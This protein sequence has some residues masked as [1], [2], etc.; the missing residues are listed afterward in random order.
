MNINEIRQKIEDLNRQY[1]DINSQLYEGAVIKSI[2]ELDGQTEVLSSAIPNFEGL[3]NDL[4][5]ISSD[6]V[7]YKTLLLQANNKVM[8]NET[9]TIQ[10]GIVKIQQLR[11]L[12]SQLSSI[13][14]FKPTK[15][16]RSDNSNNS[17][18]Y[19]I[20][21]LNFSKIN[22]STKCEEILKKVNLLE[23]Q[24]SK[25]NELDYII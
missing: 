10:A 23:L 1:S 15:L 5:S 3:L 22:L 24:I 20:S 14:N 9:D 25:A 12:H 17:A 21:E 7:K 16:R 11:K 4:E 18:Y 2:K 8:I 13:L 19:Q 6:L